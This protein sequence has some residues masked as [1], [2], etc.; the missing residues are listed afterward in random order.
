MNTS[1]AYSKEAE[2]IITKIFDS[3]LLHENGVDLDL[4]YNNV[5]YIKDYIIEKC[6]EETIK[7][8]IKFSIHFIEY[9]HKTLV[10]DLKNFEPQNAKYRDVKNRIGR[11]L[12]VYEFIE[13]IAKMSEKSIEFCYKYHR[14]ES[15]NG[16]KA[17]LD[18][19]TDDI[20]VLQLTKLKENY[21]INLLKYLLTYGNNL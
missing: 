18:F 1:N 21:L 13:V 9:A 8:F 4:T 2:S 16:I 20:I 3:A 6:S 12:I 11:I 10:E 5:K 7:K 19:L 17:L 15:K 14:E